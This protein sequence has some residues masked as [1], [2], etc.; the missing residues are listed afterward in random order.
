MV[1]VVGRGQG[2]GVDEAEQ[3]G[4]GG[5]HLGVGEPDPFEGSQFVLVLPDH[6]GAQRRAGDGQVRDPGV[7][8]HEVP[9][10]LGHPGDVGLPGLPRF[11][12]PAFH[13]QVRVVEHQV[14]Q[15]RLAGDVRV[16][17][18]RR[19]AEPLRQRPHGQ[20]GQA[21]LVGERGRGPD[22]GVHAEALPRA[23]PGGLRR[24]PG[25]APQQLQRADG[26]SRAAA[27][28]HHVPASEPSPTIRY[29][30]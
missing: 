3:V 7:A 11:G 12:G 9:V 8:D 21:L 19:H 28:L 4:Q 1:G 18:H 6:S 17:G 10:V 13:V 14:E 20:R 27:V 15:L 26:V 30:V 16:D 25:L 23:A 5:V 2:V 22:D 24:L 29:T